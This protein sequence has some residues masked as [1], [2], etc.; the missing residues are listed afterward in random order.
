M[1]RGITLVFVTILSIVFISSIISAI[2]LNQ[3]FDSDEGEFSLASVKGQ[4]DGQSD[5]ELLAKMNLKECEGTCP[6]LC[7]YVGYG[8]ML[9]C[10]EC[11][12]EGCDTYPQWGNL[13]VCQG[14]C[15]NYCSEN[16][17]YSG[18]GACKDCEYELD[19]EALANINLN[20]C[21]GTCP[22]LCD[23]VGYGNMKA[24]KRCGLDGCE[25]YPQWGNLLVCKETC[26]SYC[27][28]NSDYN[29]LKACKGCN[30]S[31]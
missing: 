6:K 2:P 22:E 29:V 14:A 17:A 12:L 7:D 26:P 16:S 24:C 25:K 11:G 10:K 3:I 30:I 8:N 5:C 20:E 31:C 15:P 9:A 4:A 21:V 13:L 27:G 18:F 19:C 23:N 28:E 1:K